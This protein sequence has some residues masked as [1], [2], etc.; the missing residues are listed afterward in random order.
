MWLSDRDGFFHQT[1]GNRW[2][3]SSPWSSRLHRRQVSSSGPARRRCKVS[4]VGYLLSVRPTV[5]KTSRFSASVGS[6]ITLAGYDEYI[7]VTLETVVTIFANLTHQIYSLT[8]GFPTAR[9]RV[10]TGLASA[11]KRDSCRCVVISI[12]QRHLLSYPNVG[13]HFPSIFP[14]SRC[15]T[16][17]LRASP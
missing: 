8:S 4:W 17:L 1:S 12:Q 9:E 15:S 13:I 10:S 6:I 3:W 11:S 7:G 16:E 14:F 5:K 2:P